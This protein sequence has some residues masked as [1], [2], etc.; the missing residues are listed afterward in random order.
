MLNVAKFPVL[1]L[2]YQEIAKGLRGKGSLLESFKVRVYAV[3]P[4][5]LFRWIPYFG[6]PSGL[7][8][9]YLHV[10][11]LNRLHEVSLGP[12]IAVI[13]FFISIQV[14]WAISLGWV[15]SSVPW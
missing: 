8:A 13:N 1:G 11:A 5:L 12:A 2:I 3:A 7:W 9:G 6:L 4:T 10:I 15:G 14:I